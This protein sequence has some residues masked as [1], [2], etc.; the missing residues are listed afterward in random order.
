MRNRHRRIAGVSLLALSLI[1]LS[2]SSSRPEAPP[3]KIV[4]D[5]AMLRLA[6]TRLPDEKAPWHESDYEHDTLLD[7]RFVARDRCVT[8]EAGDR[9]AHVDLYRFRVLSVGTGKFGDNEL[10]FLRVMHFEKGVRYKLLMLRGDLRFWLKTT[11]DGFVVTNIERI[12]NKEL[13][14]TR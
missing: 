5:D 14:A 4:L 1:G 13:K 6:N 11:E 2:C 8:A 7:G 10:Q 9:Y 12:P 3:I